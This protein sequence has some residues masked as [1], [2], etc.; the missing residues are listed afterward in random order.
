[1]ILNYGLCKIMRT[2]ILSINYLSNGE[3]S[4]HISC[5]HNY[6]KRDPL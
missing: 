3:H 5:E 6:E 2:I 1:M 4:K